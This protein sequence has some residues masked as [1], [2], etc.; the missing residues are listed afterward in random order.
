M[1]VAVV[2]QF[3]VVHVNVVFD[4][5]I[6]FSDSALYVEVGSAFAS[7]V[8]KGSECFAGS[9]SRIVPGLRDQLGLLCLARASAYRRI[10]FILRPKTVCMAS[11]RFS[12]ASWS[13][14]RTLLSLLCSSAMVACV[15]CKGGSLNVC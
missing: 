2:V 4:Q 15:G 10:S 9:C 8:G 6:R 13:L 1:V 11:W 3:H 7:D 5:Y 14:L 12:G